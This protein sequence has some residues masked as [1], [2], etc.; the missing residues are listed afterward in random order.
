MATDVLLA[1]AITNAD[2]SS[3]YLRFFRRQQT[4]QK[5]VILLEISTNANY[6]EI[7]CHAIRKPPC[8]CTG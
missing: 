5:F 7:S 2:Y 3:E 8:C 1:N 6:L 4:F